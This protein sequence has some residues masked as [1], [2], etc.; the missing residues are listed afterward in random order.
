[1]LAD[2]EVL[3]NNDS[4]RYIL[5]NKVNKTRDQV[6]YS[7]ACTVMKLLGIRAATRSFPNIKEL[8]TY[9]KSVFE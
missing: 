2:I 1:M 9:V 4:G 5:I 6:S 7:G 8:N 3:Q